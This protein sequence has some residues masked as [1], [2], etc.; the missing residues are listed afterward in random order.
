MGRLHFILSHITLHFTYNTH[1]AHFTLGLVFYILSPVFSLSVTLTLPRFLHITLCSRSTVHICI[2]S[3]AKRCSYNSP[4][5]RS[6]PYPIPSTY[7][8]KA[9]NRTDTARSKCRCEINNSKLGY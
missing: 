7:S 4:A 2:I 3:I 8:S 5:Q 6:N 9:V 1:F